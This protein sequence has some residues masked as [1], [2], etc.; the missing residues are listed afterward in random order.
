MPS[1]RPVPDGFEIALD[2][3]T[4]FRYAERTQGHLAA[5]QSD[6]Q[7]GLIIVREAKGERAFVHRSGLIYHAGNFFAIEARQA[8]GTLELAELK[9]PPPARCRRSA[10]GKPGSRRRVFTL[11][12]VEGVAAPAPVPVAAADSADERAGVTGCAFKASSTA[13][14]HVAGLEQAVLHRHPVH[15][16]CIAIRNESIL[17]RLSDGALVD[18]APGQQ[19]EGVAEVAASAAGVTMNGE[20]RL[21]MRAVQLV[22][23]W[24]YVSQRRAS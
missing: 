16:A 13:G 20:H 18:P 7:P 10:G 2:L 21:R 8:F 3:E 5:A 11:D 24:V 23:D 15:G 12:E 22:G 19:R 17:F 4:S 9:T 6:E 1:L 14:A